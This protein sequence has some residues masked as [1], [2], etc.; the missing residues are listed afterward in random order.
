MEGYR[1]SPLLIPRFSRDPAERERQLARFLEGE[2]TA[3]NQL[4]GGRIRWQN[5][6]SQLIEYTIEDDPA[7][8]TPPGTLVITPITLTHNLGKVPEFFIP[9]PSTEY[10]VWATATDRAAWDEETIQ[11]S[12]PASGVNP[13]PATGDILTVLVM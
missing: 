4:L 5:L 1:K 12:I 6:R 10:I 9:N 3:I 13:D 8:P 7:D 11:L 2:F